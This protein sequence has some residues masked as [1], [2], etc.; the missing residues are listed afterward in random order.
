[1]QEKVEVR[2]H[3]AITTARYEYSELQLDIFFYLLSM[4]KKD[5]PSGVYEIV[6]KDLSALTGKEYQYNYLKKAT[7]EMGSRMFEVSTT[8]SYK[9]LWMF[10]RVE[11][12]LGEGRIEIEFSNPI[13]PYLFE[14]KDNFTSFEL[15]AALR[16][17]SKYGKRLY[18]L[19]S[20][21][22]DKGE[23]PKTTIAELKRMLSL[24]DDK[25]NE[26]FEKIADFKRF[27]LD[28]AKKQINKHTDLY[29]DY[30]LEKL[31]RSYHF[32]TFTVRQQQLAALLPLSAP[33]SLSGESTPKDI[34]QA[35]YENARQL[36]DMWNIKRSDLV[37]QIMSSK[38]YIQEV[39]K[40]AHQLQTGKVKVEKNIAGYLLTRLG[41]KA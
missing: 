18:T 39:N 25:G 8:K 38:A 31:G 32:I 12:M 23:I 28:E 2:H 11:Y 29:I 27:V 24:R 5:S 22:K 19:C 14:L 10:Q 26:K 37:N 40:F 41:L 9:Q 13:K 17:G 35:Q 21:W 7:E 3:N 36:L 4:L 6:V 1:M 33:N 15:Y 16:L 20:Q 34:T 30:K